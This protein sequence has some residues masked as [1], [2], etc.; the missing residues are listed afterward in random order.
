M[1]IA[2]EKQAI[3]LIQA[4]F[5]THLL[6]DAGLWNAKPKPTPI[7]TGLKIE[8]ANVPIQIKDFRRLV[9]KIQ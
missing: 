6:Q 2:R 5:T 7:K 9:S 3:H 8:P 1:K 4:K